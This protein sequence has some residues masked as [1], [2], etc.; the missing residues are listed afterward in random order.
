MYGRQFAPVVTQSG[1]AAELDVSA[2]GPGNT[3]DTVYVW[4]FI[5][6]NTD[7][8]DRDFIFEDADDVVLVHVRVA[9]DASFSSDIPWLADNGLTVRADAAGAEATVTVYHSQ[10]GA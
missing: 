4:G 8:T 7:A 2:A 5:V 3:G 9:G 1:L 10:S 6:S